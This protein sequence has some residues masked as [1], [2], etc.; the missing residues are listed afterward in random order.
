MK[1][2]KDISMYQAIPPGSLQEE[3]KGSSVLT[4]LILRIN[5]SISIYPLYLCIYVHS[6]Y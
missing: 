1:P 2:L 6:L 3:V 5:W 4:K